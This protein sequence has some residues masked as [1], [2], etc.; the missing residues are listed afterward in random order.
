MNIPTFLKQGNQ[1][2]V[3]ELEKDRKIASKRVH[4]ER[5]IGL[6]KTF[7]ILQRPLNDV[8]TY[9][10]DHILSCCFMLCNMRSTIVP[11]DA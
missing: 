2:S 3:S 11:V 6:A 5:I 1:F 9:L 10:G 8:E 7:K 4:V